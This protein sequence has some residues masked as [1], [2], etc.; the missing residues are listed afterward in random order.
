M[1]DPLAWLR[2]WTANAR[3]LVLGIGLGLLACGAVAVEPLRIVVPSTAGGPQ[4]HLARLLAQQLSRLRDEPVIVVNKPGA[5]SAIGAE[6]VIQAPQP[7][8]TLLMAASYLALGSV[9]N[10]FRFDPATALRPVIKVVEQDTVLVA[11]QGLPVASAVELI[12]Y[13]AAGHTLSCGAGIGQMFL[14]CLQLREHWQ[15]NLTPISYN[16]VAKLITNVIGEHVDLA[17]A[18]TRDVAPHIASGHLRALAV[19]GA[20]RNTGKLFETLPRFDALWPDI[21]LK[22]YMALYA[23]GNASDAAVARWNEDINALLRTDEVKAGLALAG[24]TAVGGTPEVLAQTYQRYL[25][26]F[27]R[28]RPLLEAAG[29]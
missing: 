8:R 13:Q 4:D 16:G 10:K 29:N 12:R 7:D 22:L 21:D 25:V 18:P 26:R 14:A 23:P 3:R 24:M 20:G 6:Y 1:T 11:R 5:D 17:V 19:S 27:G 28:L 15:G 2:G 9:L